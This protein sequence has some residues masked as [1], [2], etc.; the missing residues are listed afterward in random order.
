MCPDGQ[1]LSVYLDGELPSPWKEKME[2]HLAS[3]PRCRETLGVWR[4]LSARLDEKPDSGEAQDRVWERLAALTG[5]ASGPIRVSGQR[6]VRTN[7]WRRNVPLPFTAA[8][9]A[10]AAAL[11][12]V[13]T[14]ILLKQP[15]NIPSATNP[16]ISAELDMNVQGIVPVSDMDSVL[17]YLE[18]SDD[19][20]IMIIRLPESRRFVNAGDPMIIKA[21]YGSKP[22]R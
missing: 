5:Q 11:A 2:R 15:G 9:A 17:R 3:C 6:P 19:S 16:P 18:R 13:F 12:I 8:L 20:D 10:A 7:M 1:L 22:Q 14:T 4:Q 21:D